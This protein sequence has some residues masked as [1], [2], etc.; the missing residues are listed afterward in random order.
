MLWMEGCAGVLGRS[1][2]VEGLMVDVTGRPYPG[3]GVLL[4]LA[5]M[6]G[7]LVRECE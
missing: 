1:Y 3:E 2:Y 4:C 6:S 7:R 5:A